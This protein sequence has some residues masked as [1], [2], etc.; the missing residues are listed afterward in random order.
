MRERK[1]EKKGMIKWLGENGGELVGTKKYLCVQKKRI[2]VCNMYMLR[3]VMRVERCSSAVA[4]ECF[5]FFFEQKSSEAPCIKG[6]KNTHQA[7]AAEQ[8]PTK[9]SPEKRNY[10]VAK[11]WRI[12]EC[13]CTSEEFP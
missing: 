2:F 1:V 13:T 9:A 3:N 6:S 5:F 10:T 7:Q 8:G 4:L 12:L 11:V